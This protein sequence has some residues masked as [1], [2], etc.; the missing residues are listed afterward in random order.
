MRTDQSST[1]SADPPL[2]LAAQTLFAAALALLLLLALVGL[3]VWASLESNVV[4]G[5]RWLLSTRW[6]VA[7]LLDVYAGAFVVAV[8]MRVSTRST[9][10]WLA[11][12]AALLCLGHAVSLAYLLTRLARGRSLAAAYGSPH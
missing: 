6:G 8:W 9:A 5:F 10:A 11:W 2:R 4:D 7:T 3:I 12:V 1:N